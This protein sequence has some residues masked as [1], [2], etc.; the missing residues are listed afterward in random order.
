MASTVSD[1]GLS[2][3]ILPAGA[4]N[5]IT[6]VP[7]VRVGHCTLRNGD[8]NTGVTAILPHG[9]NLFRKKVTAASHVINGFGK[10]IGLTQVQELGSIETP[11]LLTNTL[12][13]GT[14]ATALIRD[15]IRQNPD[16]GR[17]TGT[18]NP[19]VGECNDGPLNDIQALAISE[20]H[21]LAALADAHEGEVEQGNVG[22][23]TGMTCFGFKGGIGSASRRIALGG[24]HHL[25]VLVL[26]NFGR[27]G[28]LVLPDGRRP[29]SGQPAGDE[30][31]S[32]MIVLATDVPLEHRQLER[33]ARRAGAGIAR[34]GSFWG[35]GSGDI[36]IAFSTGNLVDHD[37]SRDL[38][39]L[40]ALN[41]ARID[42]L[43][44]AAAE[45]TQEAVLNSMLSAEA[46]TGRA[47][48]HRASLADWLRDQQR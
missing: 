9:G 17:S 20:E 18:V 4:H 44:R 11:V 1:F 41:E 5:A 26:S 35:H 2:C 43:F 25:G 23:G 24:G 48:K 36:A 46:F 34:L 3:G 7:G 27:P 29:T 47:G 21:A 19:L 32:V 10:T 31:G 8:T 22:A 33:V 37:E 13:V 30:R 40:L 39:P 12:S 28:D 45:A 6:D 38:V 15:A 16:I 14:C 42:I